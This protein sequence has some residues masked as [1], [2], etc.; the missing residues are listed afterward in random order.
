RGPAGTAEFRYVRGGHR[1]GSRARS[2]R[3][4][5]MTSG[6]APKSRTDLGKAG[7]ALSYPAHP[8]KTEPHKESPSERARQRVS[9]CNTQ[10]IRTPRH[11]LKDVR[12]KTPPRRYTRPTTAGRRT[13][14]R[15]R[16]SFLRRRLE[17]VRVVGEVRDAEV[18]FGDHRLGHQR[19]LSRG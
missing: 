5:R 6:N 15:E 17:Q 9:P 1:S 18:D 19:V 2:G 12:W 10:P 8:S 7:N 3:H 11:H 13:S 14:A 4:R 16:L